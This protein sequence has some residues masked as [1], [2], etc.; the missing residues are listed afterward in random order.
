MFK[1]NKFNYIKMKI[2]IVFSP[3][4][5]ANSSI[6][7]LLKD[8]NRLP[9]I[10]THDLQ[11]L[12][13]Y[14]SETKF[15]L[16]ILQKNFPNLK[17]DKIGECLQVD[18]DDSY[19]HKFWNILKLKNELKIITSL[20]HPIQKSISSFLNTHS[21]E[22]IQKYVNISKY[23]DLTICNLPDELDYLED[24]LEKEYLD[25]LD[26][27]EIYNELHRNIMHE[28]MEYYRI[29]STI[30][31]VTYM[32]FTET[33]QHRIINPNL[34][35]FTFKYESIDSVRLNLIKFLKLKTNIL[36]PNGSSKN[37]K[38]I[39]DPK[40][41]IDDIHDI[42]ETYAKQHFINFNTMINMSKF[43]YKV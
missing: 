5:S 18:F 15:L 34:E 4:R 23:S 28:Y 16:K 17:I 33:S 12:S 40:Y 31:N 19:M 8:N 36:I 37:K 26:I 3:T 22:Y 21:I 2:Y 14:D 20:R 27:T 25:I 9:A 38:Y 29:L 42:L 13:I 35:I 43:N 10:N 1:I 6:F 39:F 11:S 24:Y 32:S 7:K 30:F 41:T